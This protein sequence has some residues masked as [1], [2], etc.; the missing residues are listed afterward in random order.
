M[1]AHLELLLRQLKVEGIKV[2][3]DV[4]HARCLGDDAGS[5]LNGPSDQDLHT[6]EVLRV[7]EPHLH[8][9]TPVVPCF[10]TF[11]CSRVSSC[12]PSSA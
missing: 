7:S 4:G 6:T 3:L 10:A 8:V 2:A 1:C 9:L 11:P 12:K 5:I